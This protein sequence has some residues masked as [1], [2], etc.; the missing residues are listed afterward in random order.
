VAVP[1]TD[2]E[3]AILELE[4]TWWSQPGD[5]NELIETRLGI[6]PASYYH[7]LNELIDR[8]DAL[9]AD[10]L[11]VRRLRRLRDRRR[12]ARM[13]AVSSPGAFVDD[14]VSDAIDAGSES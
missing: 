6:E 13:G 14:L 12:R 1:L 4:R 10:P 7:Q 3:K 8:P 5:K 9:A 11:V 2:A